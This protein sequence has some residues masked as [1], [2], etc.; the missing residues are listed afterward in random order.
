MVNMRLHCIASTRT[1]AVVGKL[2][3]C[4]SAAA[5]KQPTQVQLLIIINI[6][7]FTCLSRVA[8]SLATD[9]TTGR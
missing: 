9:W 8:Q 1:H 7:I 4:Y 2:C 6:A 3:C 5:Y